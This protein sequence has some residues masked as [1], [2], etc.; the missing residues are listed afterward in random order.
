VG[1]NVGVGVLGLS[2]L[3]EDTRSDLV[4]LG[5]ELE[6][7]VLRKLLEG[8]LALGG[9]TGVGLTENGVSVSGNDT[10]SVK[11]GPEVV[12]DGG[13]RKVVTDG[14]L[15]LG[16]PVKD[17]LVGKSVKGT[18][19]TVKSGSEGEHGGRESGS[20]Q[21]G[22]VGRDVSS[23][24]VRVDGQ[25][26]THEVNEV[27]VSSE[28]ELVGQV[29]TVVLVLLDLGDLSVLVDVTVDL[30]GNGGEL[31]NEVHGVLEGVVPVLL[32]VDSLGVSLSEGRLVLKSGDG[33]RELSHGVEGVGAAVDELLNELG[34]IGTGSPLSGESADL[35]LS[36][37]LSGQQEPEET[38]REGLLSSGSAGKDS[39]AL[40]DLC[41]CQ[42]CGLSM[43]RRGVLTVF[44]RKRIPSS[45]SRTD[46]SQTRDLTPRA[47]P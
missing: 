26:K 12:L 33:K 16:E 25:V 21:V 15:H 17:L 27:L 34:D 4:D 19:K 10:S 9:V 13:V 18:G 40:R 47:P 8:E 35:L 30:S 36:G 37:N 3:G 44:P 29:E 42:Y 2:V 22:G 7:R 31:G 28:S 41:R 46:P 11:G 6:E 20:D 45:A 24:V 38:L 1:V 5:D 14:L 43:W 32:L 39:L 23:L